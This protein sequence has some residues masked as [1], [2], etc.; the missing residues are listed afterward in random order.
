[1]FLS[2]LMLQIQYQLLTIK[3][4]RFTEAQILKVLKQ[5][6]AGS[7]VSDLCRELIIRDASLY[8]W[9][10]KYGGMKVNDVKRMKSIEVEDS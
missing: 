3:K 2:I 1:M 4:T 7:K 5:Q 8:N 9:K 10:A 6:K